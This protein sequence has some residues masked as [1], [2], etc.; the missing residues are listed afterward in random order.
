ME[1]FIKL[2]NDPTREVKL[3]QDSSF[4]FLSWVAR[5]APYHPEM[6]ELYNVM[7]DAEEYSVDNEAFMAALNNCL[8]LQFPDDPEP[9]NMPL[10]SNLIDVQPPNNFWE[11]NSV[12]NGNGNGE[13]DSGGSTEEEGGGY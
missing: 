1:R 6:Q 7:L 11:R 4:K 9:A 8:D 12:Q 3:N 2:A 13:G 5:R 10:N